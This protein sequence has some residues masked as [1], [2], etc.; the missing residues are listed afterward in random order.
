[1]QNKKAE[2]ANQNEISC[3]KCGLIFDN[4]DKSGTKDTH[5]K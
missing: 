4:S 1:M 5:V 3:F 2:I